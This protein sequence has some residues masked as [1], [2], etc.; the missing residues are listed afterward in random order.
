MVEHKVSLVANEGIFE[1]LAKQN[2]Q[3]HQCIG[4]L[5]DNSIA[6]KRDSQ[7]FRVDIIFIKIGSDFADVYVADNC[8]G[9]TLDVM[10]KSL[11]L[12][13]PATTTNRLN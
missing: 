4:E 12:G 13:V 7:K 5:V 11:Q 2:I 1:G 3:F 10:K 6:A 8:K 9:M